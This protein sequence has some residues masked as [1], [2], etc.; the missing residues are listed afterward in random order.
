MKNKLKQLFRSKVPVKDRVPFWQKMA[1]GLGGPVEGTA[2]WIP[3][4]NLLP[5][6][7]IGLGMNPAMISFVLMIWRAW[8]GVADLLMGQM[9]DNARTRWGRRK[10]FIVVGA[11]LT[12]LVLPIMWWAPRGMADWQTCAWL[13]GSGILFYTCFALWAM[14]YYSLH[15]EMTPDYDERTNITAYR[16]MS[17]MA[18]NLLAGGILAWAAL[19]MFSTH[20]DGSPDLANGMRYVSIVLAVITIALG[21]LPG[22]FVKER[23]YAET[24]RQPKQK[25]LP[26]LKLTLTTRPFLALIA[27]VVTKLMSYALVGS[28]IFYLNAYYV[29]RG[30]I[31]QAAKI[32]WL[33]QAVLVGPNLL[34]IPLCTWLATR[35]GKHTLL[36]IIAIS[37]MLH[38]LSVYIF[39]TPE[40]PWL[41]VVSFLFLGPIGSGIWL[42]APAMQADIV[43]YDEWKNGVRREGSFAAVF[44]WTCKMT[45]TIAVA[46]GGLLLVWTGYKIEYGS[47]QPEAVLSNLKTAYIWIPIGLLLLNL[48]FI[49]KYSLTRKRMAGI[50][51]DLEAR[52]GAL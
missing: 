26:G 5:V 19:P 16:A 50:R 51:R 4:T 52:R 8:D 44:S 34:G 35:F 33:R 48:F 2:V 6:F 47:Q 36:Y 49:S 40:H 15:L 25:L 3:Q 45:N 41:L 17:Q 7:N 37:G 28:L 12:G 32:E 20:A 29:C 43:D 10:P 11:I 30:D 13:L 42:I 21:V 14:P 1:Y 39:F 27:I 38:Y 31:A 18:L 46:L 22:L 24:R 9:S 23:F